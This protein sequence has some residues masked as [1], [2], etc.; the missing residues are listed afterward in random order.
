MMRLNTTV[1]LTRVSTLALLTLTAFSLSAFSQC[2]VPPGLQAQLTEKYPQWSIVTPDK[3]GRD[4]HETWKSLHPKECPGLLQ[5]K[6]VDDRDLFA[7]ALVQKRAG[8]IREQVVL[9]EPQESGWTIVVL[10]PAKELTVT[11]VLVKLPPGRYTS[12]DG[13]KK[14]KISTESIDVAQLGAHASILYW[15]EGQFKSLLWSY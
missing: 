6:F 14:V 1:L 4:D 10:V 5:G 13:R 2:K 11:G 3:L 8:R 15:D 7:V 12:F 9:F